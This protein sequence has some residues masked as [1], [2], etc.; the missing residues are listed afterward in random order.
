M[1]TPSKKNKKNPIDEALSAIGNLTSSYQPPS[2]EEYA[3]F[4]K[5]MLIGIK[6]GKGIIG[7][8]EEERQLEENQ[9]QGEGSKSAEQ[10]KTGSD[11]SHESQADHPNEG[12][13]GTAPAD[14]ELI[15]E[16]DDEGSEASGNS[17]DNRSDFEADGDDTES[18]GRDT[19]NVPGIEHP[20]PVTQYFGNQWVEHI[21][22]N[23]SQPCTEHAL[24][25]RRPTFIQSSPCLWIS[26]CPQHHMTISAKAQLRSI[27]Y[28]SQSFEVA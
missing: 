21:V 2:E 12:V 9:S 1:A 19:V 15:D 22:S 25:M 4:I 8:E 26:I 23:S 13:D 24:I 17:S 20:I 3:E 16:A 27:I 11:A 28:A 5:R 10:Q 7:T 6:P 18:G 14:E